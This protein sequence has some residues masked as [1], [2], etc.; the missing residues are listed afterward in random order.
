MSTTTVPIYDAMGNVTGF[1]E[2]DIP[3]TDAAANVTPLQLDYYRNK[4][5]EFQEVLDNMD[6]TAVAARYLIDEDISPGVHAGH[7]EFSRGL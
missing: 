7:A 6:A 2:T 5:R 3:E 1:Q 4:V